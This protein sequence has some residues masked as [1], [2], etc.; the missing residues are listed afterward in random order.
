VR[1]ARVGSLCDPAREG[2]AMK[3]FV[4]CGLVLLFALGCERQSRKQMRL[5]VLR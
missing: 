4:L 2:R 5:E 1:D 3:R